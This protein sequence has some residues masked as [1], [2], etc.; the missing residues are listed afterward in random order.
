MTRARPQSMRDKRVFTRKRELGTTEPSSFGCRTKFAA[1]S[2]ARRAR[3]KRPSFTRRASLSRNG[4]ASGQELPEQRA[5]WHIL[6]HHTRPS[7]VL[8]SPGPNS[9]DLPIESGFDRPHRL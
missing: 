7:D 6:R 2:N 4:R 5:I 3:A 1:K 8:D 9:G